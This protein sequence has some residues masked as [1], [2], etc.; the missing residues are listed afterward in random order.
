MSSKK[1]EYR[2]ESLP[3]YLGPE[4]YIQ[5]HPR[6]NSAPPN[7]SPQINKFCPETR[8]KID[9]NRSYTRDERLWIALADYHNQL[10]AYN[11]N[12][13]DKKAKKPK[14][15]QIAS[16]YQIPESTLRG[17]IHHP[18]RKTN[19]EIH[20]NQQLLSPSEEDELAQ[21]LLFMDDFNIPATKSDCEKLALHILKQHKPDATRIGDHWLYR[22]LQRHNECQFIFTKTMKRNRA[23]AENWEIIDDFCWKVNCKFGIYYK[24]NCILIIYN[25]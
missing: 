4:K 7:F 11:M 22:F 6:P 3:I 12:S 8:P 14:V 15:T 1:T 16:L 20:H 17:H 18:E 5:F 23:N 10:K 19:T 21:R 13:F 25:S 24:I 9:P 2:S